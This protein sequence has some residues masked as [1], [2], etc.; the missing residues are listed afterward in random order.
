MPMTLP[1]QLIELLVGHGGNPVFDDYLDRVA[2]AGLMHYQTVFQ[3]GKKHGESLYMHVLDGIGVLETMMPRLNLSEPEARVLYT[4]FTIHDIN[5]V[6]QSQEA[7]GKLAVPDNLAQE[8]RRLE[9]EDFFPEW[10]DFLQDITSLVRAHSGHHHASGESWIVKRDPVY[11]LGLKRVEALVHLMRAADIIGLS[12]SL[13]EHTHKNTFLGHLNAY[14]ADS[15]FDQQ[16]EFHTHQLVE[17]RGLLSNVLHNALME[18]FAEREHW[19]PLLLY[20]DGVAYLTPKG[21]AFQWSEDTL[22]WLGQ[23]VGDRINGLVQ[24]DAMNLLEQTNQGIKFKPDALTSGVPFDALWG[25]VRNLVAR[26]KFKF[27]DLESNARKRTEKRLEKL[28]ARNPSQ[29]SALEGRLQAPLIQA[30]EAQMR[31]AELART[32]YIFL[33]DYFTLDE[34]PWLRIYRLLDLPAERY[35]FYT[36]FDERYDQAYVMAGDIAL[37]EDEVFEQLRDDGQSLLQAVVQITEPN[38]L[39]QTYLQHYLVVDNSPAS[40]DGWSSHLAHYVANQH[41]Q[42]VHCSAPFE[43]RE[44]MAGDVRDDIKVQV[45][46]NRLVGGTNREPKKSICAVC[47]IQFLLEA[48]NYVHIRGENTFYL[49]LCPYTFLTRPFLSGLIAAFNRLRNTDFPLQALN[50]DAGAAVEQIAARHPV[51]PQF[52]TQ[53][54]QG[55]AEPY[56]LYVAQYADTFAGA[57]VFPVNPAG[58]NDTERFLFALWYALTLQRYFNV[59]ALLSKDAVPPLQSEALPDLFLDM[60]PLACSGLL[61]RNDYS[62]YVHTTKQPGPLNELWNRVLDLFALRR[63]LFAKRDETPALVRALT[64]GPLH[65]FHRADR[66]MLRNDLGWWAGQDAF[67]HLKALA[68]YVGG[69]W[70]EQLSEILNWLAEL[71]WQN[72]LLGTSL[73]RSSLLFPVAEVF[74]KLNALGAEPDRDTLIAATA[75]DIFNHLDRIADDRYKPGRTKWQAVEQFVRGWYDHVLDGVY[76]GNVQKMLRDEKL[77]RSAYLFYVQVQIPQKSQEAT[78]NKE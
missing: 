15:G 30:T 76:R 61:P 12:H 21:T 64:D 31:A 24:S 19:L 60:I 54:K 71:A 2:N 23:E 36:C 65:V 66:I 27:D 34:G 77:L 38:D 74:T 9:L 1:L 68:L 3:H 37:S 17:Q 75:Q 22:R 69:H 42:C 62:W 44:W 25:H 40:A 29:A 14:L 6:M 63:I 43:T 10:E 41:Q 73:K 67:V 28:R 45:F 5:K 33:S 4:A 53:T 32:Y 16:Y 39:W 8:I 13:H 50:M 59:K 72:R 46:S 35:E 70:M 26:R 20:P 11:R 7:F 51:R 49:H 47:R 78:A 52:R 56:G 57:I 58:K 18:N 55:K 48:L